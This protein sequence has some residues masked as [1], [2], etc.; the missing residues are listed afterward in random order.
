LQKFE[1]RRN[2]SVE[3]LSWAPRIGPGGPPSAIRLGRWPLD[4]EVLRT[5]REGFF[6]A[7]DAKAK[8]AISAPC[9]I[10]PWIESISVEGVVVLDGFGC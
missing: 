7:A 9:G 6:D 8:E 2:Q 1:L 10:S 3:R 5:L 4:E